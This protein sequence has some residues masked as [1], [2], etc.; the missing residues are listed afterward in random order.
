MT[1]QLVLIRHAKAADGDVDIERPLTG[2]GRR[3]AGA[4]GRWLAR[5][6][7]AIDRVL[8]S[9]AQRARET[10]AAAAA[11]LPGAA[12]AEIEDR[13]YDN[14]VDT[15]LAVLRDVPDSVEGLALVG[16][17][18]SVERLANDLDDGEGDPDSREQLADGYSTSGI[19][20]FQIPGG[21]ADLREHAATLTSFAAPRG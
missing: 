20:V 13:I 6:G 4:V 19:A 1:R 16:H 5:S 14:D 2:R 17:N 12:S 7:I 8:V 18:P 21:W 10:W 11:E 15:L 3:D 9:P